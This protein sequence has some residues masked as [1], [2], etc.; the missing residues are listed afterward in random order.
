MY[1][2]ACRVLATVA[3]L[4]LP[5]PRARLV[6][7]TKLVVRQLPPQL[8]PDAFIATLGPYVTTYTYVA[9]YPGRVRCVPPATCPVHV[10]VSVHDR[11][12]LALARWAGLQQGR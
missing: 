10:C 6:T 2:C 8:G 1:V 7:K 11:A 12:H 9:V 5:P 4:Q 3:G